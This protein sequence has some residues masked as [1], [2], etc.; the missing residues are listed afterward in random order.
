MAARANRTQEA[1]LVRPWYNA[2]SI[3]ATQMDKTF[4]L[5]KRHRNL[6]IACLIFFVLAAVASGV[7][8]WAEAPEE[9]RTRALYAALLF[10]AF[11]LLFASLSCW[12]LLAYWREE[13][14]INDRQVTQQGVI[15]RKEIDLHNIT[16]AR[17][18]LVPRPG[19]SLVLRSLAERMTIYLGNFEPMERL[20]LIR[21]FRNGLPMPVQEDWDLFCSKIALP[22]RDWDTLAHGDPGPDSVRIT[23]RRWDWYFVPA[24]LLSVVI[25][26]VA[27]WK[28]QQPRMLVA[29]LMPALLWLFLRAMTPRQGLVVKRMTAE[30]GMTSFLVFEIWWLGVAAIGIMAFEIWN[31]PMPH[32][33]VVGTTAVV[34]WLAG[35]GWRAHRLDRDRQQSDL[36]KAPASLRQWVE[37][38]ERL[39]TGQGIDDATG[40]DGN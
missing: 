33:L 24:I 39:P 34:L 37:K 30:P 23:R 14:K 12:L 17:W 20:W 11:W 29:P 2:G 28:F 4:R 25:G 15:G 22:L 32:A 10:A 21:F 19:G 26:A 16:A 18:R 27:Y 3:R 31:P 6:G 5:A 7:G 40:M 35:L 1:D 9:Q 13:L 38:E 8:I 36:A